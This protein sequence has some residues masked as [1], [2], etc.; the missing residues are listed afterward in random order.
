[1]GIDC[2]PTAVLYGVLLPPAL[3]RAAYAQSHL[4]LVHVAANRAFAYLKTEAFG[5][6]IAD[7]DKAVELD[8]DYAKVCAWSNA[9]VVDRIRA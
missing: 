6:A 1:M 9:R 5:L 3:T 4:G 7:A 2:K 8:P